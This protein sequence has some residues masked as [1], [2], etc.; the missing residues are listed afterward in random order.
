MSD[1]YPTERSVM[2]GDELDFAQPSKTLAVSNNDRVKSP[3][4]QFNGGNKTT[5]S[6]LPV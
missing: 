3:H 6:Y 5:V 2:H 1:G 4:S